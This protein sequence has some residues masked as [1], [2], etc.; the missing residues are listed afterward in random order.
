MCVCV[1]AHLRVFACVCVRVHVCWLRPSPNFAMKPV[2][3][4]FLQSTLWLCTCLHSVAQY[5]GNAYQFYK[6]NDEDIC[7]VH[8][9]NMAYFSA[10]VEDTFLP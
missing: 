8:L 10:G 3:S 4:L 6:Y 7:L 9:L 5:C 1:Y 2:Q